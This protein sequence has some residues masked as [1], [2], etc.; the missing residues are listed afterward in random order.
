MQYMRTIGLH[1]SF[2]VLSL[3]ALLGQQADHVVISEFATRGAFSAQNEFAELYNPA[4]TSVR[5]AG[6]RLQ[7]KSATGTTWS[8]RATL[9][10]GAVIPA[11]S[12]YLI[13]SALYMGI[14]TPDYASITWTIGIADDGNLRLLNSSTVEIDRVG[15]GAAND[16]EG[17]V[18]APNHGT[19]NNNNSVE[20]KARST[21]T[22]DSLRSGGLHALLGNGFDTNNNGNDFVTQINGRNP[23]NSSTSPEPPFPFGGNG[24]GRVRVMPQVVFAGRTI[25]SLTFSVQQ[26]SPYTLTQIRLHVPQSLWPAV[27]TSVVLFGDGFQGA[28]ITLST[29]TIVITQA[30]ITVA[31]SGTVILSGSFASPPTRGYHSFT[32]HTAVAGG[33][34]APIRQQPQVRVLEIVSIVFV[35]VNDAQGVPAPPYQIG[36]QVTVTGIVTANLSSTRTDI[37]VQDETAGIN[38]FSF[39]LPPF[40]LLPGDS[41]TVTGSILQFRGLTEIS[42]EFALLERHA[43]GRPVPTPMVMTCADVN[44]TFLPD[45]SEPNESRLI[46][47][48]GVSYNQ[49]ASTITD[50]SGTTNIFIPNTFPPTPSVFDIIGI[51]KQ[52]KPGTPAPGPPY[53]SDYEI[54]PRD[55]VGIVPHPGPIITSTPFEDAIQPSSVRI[56]WRTN[57]PSTSI[58]RYGTSV[59]YTD[60]LADTS[61]VIS[62]SVVLIGLSAATVYYYSVGSGNADGINFSPQ[63]ILSTASPPQ[64]TGIINAYFNKSVNTILAWFQTAQGNQNLVARLLVR[65]NNA[66]RSIDAAVYNLSG[67]PGPGND[68]AVALKNAKDRGVKVRVICEQ[69]E[70]NK[71]PFNYLVANGIPLVTDSYDAINAG[72]GLMHNKFFIIDGRTGAPESVWVWTGSWNPTDP[73]TNADYQNSVEI[74]DVAL[75]RAFT[76]EFNEMW[77]SD[78]DVP[79][80][81]N[82][83]FGARKTDN[84]PHR[85]V[86]AGR[87]VECYFSPSDRTTSKIIAAINNAQYSVGFQLLTFTRTDI[88]NA[89]VAKKNAGLT[90]RG[91]LDNNTDQGSQYNYLLSNGVDVKLKT[92]SGLLHHKYAIVDAENP[93]W[94]ALTITGSHNWTNSAEN[95][96]SENTLIIHDGNITNQFLQE[97]AARYYQFGGTDSIVVSVRQVSEVP[98]RYSLSQNFP[99]PFNPSTY[100]EYSVPG[101]GN[102]S[103][104]VYDI[105]GREISTLINAHQA[106]GSYRVEFSAYGIASGVYFYRLEAGPYVQQKKMAVVK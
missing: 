59:V 49:A 32:V 13:S 50:A 99:N 72:A 73:G 26:D 22:A 58:V 91:D 7:Y 31:D 37:Y 3:S 1:L 19:S 15:Y 52:F 96:N 100:V 71:A 57:V 62:H 98:L 101:N 33:T 63:Y 94:G 65:I 12:F 17:G 87:N 55:P 48:N 34:P 16:P 86:I 23:Q 84:T 83:R 6:W 25:P 20:R 53:T 51:L 43:T 81:A 97:C 66:R 45:Y 78:T 92:G 106:A 103:L 69:D 67:T 88:A 76:L 38:L 68:V 8:E 10:S 82:S 79:S 77:G 24:T 44:N 90:V 85:F 4:D 80:H 56:Q 18:P 39:D 35:H 47:I 61:R 40:M 29:D 5:I 14:P 95:S 104:K 42:P 30:A 21:S 46:R 2:Q 70:R 27:I 74:Q 9:P 41:I 54:V 102:V 64:S 89:L 60:S 105:L 11:R 93:N 28:A 75:A 36:A